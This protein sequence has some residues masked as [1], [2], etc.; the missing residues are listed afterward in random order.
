M[1]QFSESSCLK[2]E[3]REILFCYDTM[4]ERIERIGRIR[5]DFF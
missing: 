3:M 5:T 1:N 2:R 4:G